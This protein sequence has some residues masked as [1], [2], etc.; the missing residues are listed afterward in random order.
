MKSFKNLLLLFGLGIVLYGCGGGAAVPSGGSLISGTVENAENI[1]AYFDKI[2]LNNS[3]ESL[4]TTEIKDGNFSFPLA[5]GHEKGIY[6]VRIGAKSANLVLDGTESKVTLTADL[7]K[8]PN[9]YQVEGSDLTSQY[10]EKMIGY[11]NKSID[12]ATMDKFLSDDADPFLAMVLSLFAYN[13]NVAKHGIFSKISSRLNADPNSEKFAKPYGDLASNMSRQYAQ[14][15][16]RNKVKIGQVAPEIES[17]DPKGKTRKL[18]DLKGSV[19]LL[20]FWASWCGP[21]RRANPKVVD[22]YK[23][24]KDQG[25]TVFNVSL[26]GVDARTKARYTSEDQYEKQMEASKK[27]WLD[28][29]KKDNLIWPHHVS[30]LKKWDSAAAATYGVRSIPSTFLI[31]KDGKLAAI[32]P[33]K[34]GLEEAVKKLL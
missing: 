7:N 2:D 26:D 21:C 15:Q 4:G 14:Q 5:N 30:D 22:V 16:A 9:E 19:V 32:N 1:T 17:V 28:A 18:S 29:I 12:E 33:G 25:F 3:I 23:K 24:Y 10:L 6:R 31:D 13:G 34:T 20:D 27:K 11:K 8:L